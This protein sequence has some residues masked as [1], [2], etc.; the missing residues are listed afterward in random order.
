MIMHGEFHTPQMHP[1]SL[2]TYSVKEIPIYL[3]AQI[4]GSQKTLNECIK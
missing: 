3:N 1:I 2:H 4:Q